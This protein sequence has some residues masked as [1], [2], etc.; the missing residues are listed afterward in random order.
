[1]LHMRHRFV[2]GLL[3]GSGFHSALSFPDQPFVSVVNLTMIY[4][5]AIYPPKTPRR[6]PFQEV[7]QRRETILT[8]EG[9]ELT[10]ALSSLC[11][12]GGFLYPGR[13]WFRR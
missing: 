1:M 13:R 8:T 5:L 12:C 4:R 9:T 11:L 6:F 7:Q 2:H 10:E 3:L